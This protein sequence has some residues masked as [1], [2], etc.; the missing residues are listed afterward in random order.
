MDNLNTSNTVSTK[1]S[2]LVENIANT[3][4]ALISALEVNA[5]SVGSYGGGI[6][7]HFDSEFVDRV[8]KALL[9]IKYHVT[10]LDKE[11]KN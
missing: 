4:D 7:E 1:V 8:V 10:R 3:C 9:K 6:V 2:Q 11:L 5:Q